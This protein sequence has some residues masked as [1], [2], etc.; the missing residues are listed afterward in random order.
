VSGVEEIELQSKSPQA[1]AL[2]A[3]GRLLQYLAMIH[4]KFER[5]VDCF[6]RQ[7]DA[8]G[9]ESY[10]LGI[11]ELRLMTTLWDQLNRLDGTTLGAGDTLTTDLQGICDGLFTAQNGNDLAALRTVLAERLLPFLRSW[12]AHVQG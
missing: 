11:D 7:A 1:F 9:F 5:A 6:D 8:D 12:H 4:T 3:R 2:D 10:R